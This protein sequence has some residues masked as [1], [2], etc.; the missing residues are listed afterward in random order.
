MIHGWGFD[1]S[2]MKTLADSLRDSFE[3]VLINLPGYVDQPLVSDYSLRNLASIVG[4]RVENDS[5]VLGWSMGGLVALEL[6]KHYPSKIQ[7]LVL[8]ASTP[9]FE[10]KSDWTNALSAKVLNNFICGYNSQ[11]LKTLEKFTFLAAEDSHQP[12]NWIRDLKM[13]SSGQLDPEA[14]KAGLTILKEADLRLELSQLKIS[15]TMVFGQEDTLVPAAVADEIQ[16][17]NREIN[18]SI[19]PDCG[20][21]LFLSHT[22]Q[23]ANIIRHHAKT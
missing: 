20:H 9:C 8:L 10:E 13:L 11:P 6:A 1:S 17:L 15:T 23:V 3:V 2:V 16:K 7:S 21:S 18:I 19:L 14:L 4:D 12:R 5:I 22:Q